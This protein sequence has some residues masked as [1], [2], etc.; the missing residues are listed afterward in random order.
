MAQTHLST[1]VAPNALPRLHLPRLRLGRLALP[2]VGILG[3]AFLYIPI[4]VLIV[5]SFNSGSRMGQWE[6][7]SLKWYESVFQD[8]RIMASFEVSLWVALLSTVIST[9]LGT[10]VA[11]ALDRFRFRGRTTFDG[12]LYLPVIIPDIVMALALLLFFS[13][14]EMKLSR[15]TILLGHIAFSVSYVCVVVRARLATMDR[16]LE[17]AAADLYASPFAAF[18]RVTLPLLMP[19]I[20]AGALMAFTLSIDEFVITSFIGGQGD[21]AIPVRIFSMLRFGLK[22]EIN[23]LAV[24][25][26]MMS[27][28]LVVFSLVMQNRG[29][30]VQANYMGQ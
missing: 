12:I 22:P 17:E 5:F 8:R 26:L 9:L 13:S 6:G 16:R 1:R 15:W 30:K 4:F 20:I 24:I 2:T 7:F 23:A 28:V 10:M 29:L 18:R 3:F 21:T 27:S 25:I 14:V 19:G 11:L